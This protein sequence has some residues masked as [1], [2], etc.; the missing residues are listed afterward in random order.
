M[1]LAMMDYDE[2][3]AAQQEEAVCKACKRFLTLLDCYTETGVPR[4]TMDRSLDLLRAR[5]WDVS[6]SAA[7]I[8]R[9]MPSVDDDDKRLSFFRTTVDTGDFLDLTLPWTLFLR[10]EIVGCRFENADLFCQKAR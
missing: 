4:L 1:D 3:P 6:A 9:R 7:G 10:S 5:G 8:P 2:V